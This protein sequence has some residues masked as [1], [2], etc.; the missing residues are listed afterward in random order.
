MKM[1]QI[2]RG[3]AL[4]ALLGGIARIGMAPSAVIWGTDSQQELYFGFV[5][6]LLMG[7]GIFGVYLYEAH[8]LGMI[9][10]LSVLLISLSSTLTAGLV[11]STMLG[12]SASSSDFIAPMQNINSLMALIG[13]LGF[14]ILTLRA[15][16]YPIW[17]V[18]LFLLFPVISFIPVVTDWAT[19]AWGLS[20]IGFGYY[21]LANKTVK[22]SSYFEASV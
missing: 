10:F 21:V 7:V 12:V 8:R 6:C 14:C 17:T 15:R 2:T 19:V 20:Y 5:A 13:M 16:I 11:W 4:T 18:V 9:G 1:E 3:L 22:N